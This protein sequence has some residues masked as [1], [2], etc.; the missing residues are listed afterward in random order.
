MIIGDLASL[1]GCVLGIE[2][3]TTAI[4]FVALGT[5]LPDTFASMTAA[6]QDR[7]ADASIGNVT[8]SNSVNVFLGLGLP[9]LMAA[10]YWSNADENIEAEWRDK[11]QNESWYDDD[12]AVGFAVPAGDLSFS[13][14]VFSFCAVSTIGFLMLRRKRL[15]YELGM[16]YEKPTTLFFIGLWGFYVCASILK[17]KKM[18]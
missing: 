9:W 3:A 4:T 10:V 14:Q 2:D 13:V 5:S 6:Q 15:G 18:I 7:Y 16:A 12:K 1:F 11:Y 17:T 8:G